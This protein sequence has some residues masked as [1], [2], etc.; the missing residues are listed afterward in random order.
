MPGTGAPGAV[1]GYR[2]MPMSSGAGLRGS[3]SAVGNP[4]HFAQV[5]SFMKTLKVVDI[6]IGGDETFQDV[7]QR[8]PQFIEKIYN[9]RCLHSALGYRPPDEF[10][11]QLVPHVA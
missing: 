6:S 9:A 10:E 2:R 7:A 5:E 8:W 3:M 11:R 1:Y 4:C